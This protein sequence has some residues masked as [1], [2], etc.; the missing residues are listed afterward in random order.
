LLTY[1][2]GIAVAGAYA[3]G[4]RIIKTP[5]NLVIRA[6]KQVLFQKAGEVNNS[7]DSLASL[8]L[9]AT[10]GLFGLAF[11]PALALFIW[12]P[13]IFTIIFGS[14]W[15][16]AGEFVRILTIWMIFMFCNV[17][18]VLF[19]RIIRVQRAVFVYEVVLLAARALSLV[20]GGLYLNVFQTILVFSLIGAGMNLFL[21]FLVGYYV[22]K[23]DRNAAINQT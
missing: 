10:I 7:N 12:G 1:F 17:P 19:A 13:S 4:M 15:L 18:A 11:F 20:L 2:Y 8:Y 14:Q 9:L 22:I 6:L 16:M 3:F 21:I 23:K 5:I